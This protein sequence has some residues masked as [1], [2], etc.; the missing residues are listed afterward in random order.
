M[1]LRGGVRATRTTIRATMSSIR[2]SAKLS[3]EI[4]VHLNKSPSQ[5]LRLIGRLKSIPANKLKALLAKISQARKNRKNLT[6]TAEEAEYWASFEEA[7]KEFSGGP[8]LNAEQFAAR[9]IK[10]YIFSSREQ[11][12]VLGRLLSRNFGK[13]SVRISGKAA[14]RK[15]EST[16]E[17]LVSRIKK[18][19][20]DS[21]PK[22]GKDADGA[23]KDVFESLKKENP[24]K[25]N[26]F[27]RSKLYSLWRQR[28]LRRI[29]QDEKLRN[30]L[31]DL[32]GVVV[33]YNKKTKNYTIHIRAKSTTGKRTQVPIDFDHDVIGHSEAV[34]KSIRTNDYKHLKSTV[35]SNN[36]QLLTG[37]ENRNV[38]ESLRAYARAAEA[39]HKQILT[40]DN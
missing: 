17:N 5:M 20:D 31:R 35:N 4:T 26:K 30:E 14:L 21:L 11:A 23:A 8:V 3:A 1:L 18:H 25:P 29:Y 10:G 2:K 6:L 36:L 15:A 16:A 27:V 37:R 19:W 9:T 22:S 7:F 38:V 28:A 12:L 33:G 40:V 39:A 24:K 13:T 34:T 32:A